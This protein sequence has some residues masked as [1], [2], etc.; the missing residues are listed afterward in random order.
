T[1]SADRA[2]P[3]RAR[4]EPAIRLRRS[5][6]GAQARPHPSSH[7]G[8]EPM[9]ICACG[10]RNAD[11]EVFCAN[12]GAYLPHVGRHVPDPPPDNGVAT[13]PADVTQEPAQVIPSPD[14][15]PEPDER[16]CPRCGTGSPALRRL[17]RRCGHSFIAVATPAPWYHSLWP[18]GRRLA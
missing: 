17:C 11:G 3:D 18:R 6:R 2:P 8:D 5:G 14:A 9:I 13:P 4:R 15:P 12:D 10:W 7:R 1:A 16:V